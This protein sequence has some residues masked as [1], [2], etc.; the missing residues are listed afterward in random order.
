MNLEI[1]LDSRSWLVEVKSTRDQRV[2]MTDTQ[3]RC[4]VETG[5]GYL[6]CVVPVDAEVPLP[7]LD[8]VKTAMRFV[9]NVGSRL[10]QLCDHLAE[11]EDRRSEIT[12]DVSEGVQLEIAAS[13]VRVRVDESVWEND[14]FPL[15]ELAGRLMKI[16]DDD[17]T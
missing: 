7:G 11:F 15:D 1:A 3:A 8:D 14:G 9:Q 10:E 17:E 12:S 2:R 13:T 4:A 16:P 6:L 5:D